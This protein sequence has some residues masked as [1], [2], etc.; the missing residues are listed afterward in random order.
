MNLT[1]DFLLPSI[2]FYVQRTLQLSND[3]LK[4]ET[5]TLK[6]GFDTLKEENV[7]QAKLLARWSNAQD[8]DGEMMNLIEQCLDLNMENEALLEEKQTWGMTNETSET[9]LA[10]KS[11]MGMT[12]CGS[13]CFASEWIAKARSACE[14]SIYYDENDGT[15]SSKN[16]IKCIFPMWN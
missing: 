9:F 1:A 12:D 16:W 11:N 3:S 13:S 5:I 14:S 2:H 7:K 10:L 6:K 8:Q 4:V 15:P